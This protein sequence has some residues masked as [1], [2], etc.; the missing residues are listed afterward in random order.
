MGGDMQ[1]QGHVQVLC[2]II[3]FGLNVQEAGDAPRVRHLGSR[4]PHGEAK[5]GAGKVALEPSMPLASARDLK[6]RGHEVIT[7]KH[8]FGGYQAIRYDAENDVYHAASESRTDG[9]AAG[10]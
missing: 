6:T 4:Q 8:G 10:Y 7:R 9:A 5:K 1:P 3:D 2:N